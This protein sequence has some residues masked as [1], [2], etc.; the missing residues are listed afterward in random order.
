MRLSKCYLKSGGRLGC[1]SCHNPHLQPSPQEAPA[2]FREKCLTCHTEKSCAVPL[3]LRQHKTPG[4]D[5]AGCHMPKRDVTVISHSVLTN[6]RIVA[7]AE[8]PFPDIAFHMTTAQLPDLVHLSANP[9]KKSSPAPLILLQAYGQVML[10]HPKY[11]VRYWSMAEQLKAT[12]P[13]NIYVLEA[14]ADEALQRK[15]SDGAALAA[16][17]L[18]RAIQ[19]GSTNAA[20]FQ[21]LAELLE[22]A[23]RQN[24]AV[25]VLRQGMDLNPHDAELYRL[26]AKIYF[27]LNKAQ[28][29]CEVAAK[30]KRTFPQDDAIRALTKRCETSS[31]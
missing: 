6:H 28:Q 26:S 22:A 18:E 21:Q 15:T 24:D 17:Y 30:A 8:E 1:I 27:T 19:H 7:E 25:K 13:N 3:S 14:L 11:R 10:T 29:A 2:Y 23:N 5:C 16:Q 31:E 20:D 12:E 4:D 9:V